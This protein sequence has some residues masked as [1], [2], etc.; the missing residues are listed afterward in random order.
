MQSLKGQQ[1][2]VTDDHGHLVEL[3]RRADRTVHEAEGEGVGPVA[4]DSAE[5]EEG[6]AEHD[7]E[8]DAAVGP[9][10]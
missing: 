1:N 5:A 9:I 7:D 6:H 2:G 10:Q 8:V 4:R 3:G